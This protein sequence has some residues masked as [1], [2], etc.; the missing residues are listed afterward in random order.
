MKIKKQKESI[1]RVVKSITDKEPNIV[2][3][4]VTLDVEGGMVIDGINSFLNYNSEMIAVNCGGKTIYIYG[5]DL[6]ITSFSKS[7]IGI[8]GKIEK[9]E[10]YEVNDAQS[11]I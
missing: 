8:K 3:T 9:I 10:L 5:N 4:M 7:L 1:F 6:K 2:P 11:K